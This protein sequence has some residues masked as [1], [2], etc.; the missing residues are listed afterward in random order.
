MPR[1][2]SD[3]HRHG[4]DGVGLDKLVAALGELLLHAGHLL[5]LFGL[6]FFVVFGHINQPFVGAALATRQQQGDQCR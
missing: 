6:A 1:T 5:A 2:T 3:H 4:D